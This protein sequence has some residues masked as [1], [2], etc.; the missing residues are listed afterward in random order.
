MSDSENQAGPSS[1]NSRVKRKADVVPS[2]HWVVRK[3]VNT[4]T[5]DEA[6]S[7]GNAASIITND[8]T[9]DN[10]SVVSDT[11]QQLQEMAD[12][13]RKVRLLTIELWF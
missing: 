13:D 9:V 6:E 3:I 8:I 5:K 10:A 12:A 2:S 4:S 11:Y 7:D 1:E